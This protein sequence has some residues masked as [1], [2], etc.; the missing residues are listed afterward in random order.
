MPDSALDVGDALTSI[1]LVPVPV[2][3]LGRGPQLYNEVAGQV[4]RLGLASFLAR[5]RRT[6][7]ASSFPMMIRASEPPVKH[8]LFHGMSDNR[9]SNSNLC[10]ITT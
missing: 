9:A 2:E 4:L 6:S 1:A 7:A 5:Q 3:F 10:L 8:R